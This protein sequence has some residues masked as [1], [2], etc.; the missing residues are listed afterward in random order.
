MKKIYILL[1]FVSV[2]FAIYG[3]TSDS[4]TTYWAKSLKGIFGINQSSFTN[5]QA[6]GE[7]TLAWNTLLELEANYNRDRNSWTN[8]LKVGYGSTNQK[9]TGFR[10][11]DD[12]LS[13]RTKYGYRFAK[14]K[15]E[16][17]GSAS[18]S[19]L[20]QFDDGYNYPNDSMKISTFMAPGYVLL[21][22]G[23]EYK[24]GDKFSALFS[25]LSVKMTFVNDDSLSAAGAF[26]VEKGETFRSELGTSL[27]LD[28][29]NEIFK[30]IY[31][32]TGL[33]LFTDYA[34]NFGNV[35]IYFTNLF[36]FKINNIFA[37][38]LSFDFIY[39]DDVTIRE[40]D[41]EG[42][43]TGEGPRLQFKQVLSL[44]L[45]LNLSSVK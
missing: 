4:D 11:T 31:Y 14:E 24:K 13:F 7:N 9:S 33:L 22:L 36:V 3:Q 10:K 30:N 12:V 34:E 8:R 16:W 2:P 35:D 45:T 17:L 37:T 15:P 6:G 44:G 28:Y 26:G 18:M 39:D 32:T 20:T 40:F 25:P 19:F 27:R 38:T 23:I 5:W 42:T 1:L 21:D 41:D 43:L 29:K